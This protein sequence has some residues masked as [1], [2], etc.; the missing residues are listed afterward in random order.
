MILP[1][2]DPRANL[3]SS[4]GIQQRSKRHCRFARS[5]V[6]RMRQGLGAENCRISPGRDWF[7]YG[8]M[9][10]MAGPVLWLRATD[11]QRIAQ[12]K[13]DS[14]QRFEKKSMRPHPTRRLGATRLSSRPATTRSRVYPRKGEG[15]TLRDIDASD[16]GGLSPPERGNHRHDKRPGLLMVAGTRG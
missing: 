13:R 12:P 16:A 9:P 6:Q 8:V 5:G 15:T 1:S 4:N 3:Y 10:L 14:P 11:S 2:V 7:R